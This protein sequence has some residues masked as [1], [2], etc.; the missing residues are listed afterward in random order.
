MN[1]PPSDSFSSSSQLDLS[2][3][4]VRRVG[5]AVARNLQTDYSA[6]IQSL[7]PHTGRLVALTS[8]YAEDILISIA[9]AQALHCDL[10]LSRMDHLPP[11]LLEKW[12]ISAVIDSQLQ[13][14]ASAA[15]LSPPNA[16]CRILIAT[17]GTTGEPKLASHSLANLMGRIRAAGNAEKGSR[18][19]LTYHPATFG[20]LQVLLTA[21]AIGCDLIVPESLSVPALAE[22]ALT[23][24]PTHISATPTFWRSFLL[25]LGNKVRDLS[26]RQITLGGE[27][28]DESILSRLQTVFPG[29]KV[30]HI[31][32]STEAGALFSVRDGHAGFPA[33]WLQTGI[34]GVM[35]RIRD[36]VLEVQSP[37]AMSRYVNRDSAEARTADGW[38]ITGD[39]VEQVGDRILFRGRKDVMLNVGGAKVRPEEVEEQLFSLPE[40]ADARVYGARNPITGMIVGADIVLRP[41]LTAEAARPAVLTA[42]RAR[43][44]GYKVPR[45][46]RFVDSLD[47]S[48]AGKKQRQP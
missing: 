9:V 33:A 32:A 31:Y 35:L 12:Q 20:G 28:A 41:G 16:D 23:H 1:A 48:Q 5:A 15:Q 6:L 24:Q 37:R 30:S 47:T 2:R 39:L 13:V 4:T 18:W 26:P 8:P 7:R 3:V 27:I 25:S 14:S 40:V 10:L 45:I 44:E 46:L 38:L 19:L 22:A 36:G 21:L 43:L 17:S 34:D 42:L 11:E 29:A